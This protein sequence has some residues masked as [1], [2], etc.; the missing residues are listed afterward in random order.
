M[1]GRRLRISATGFFEPNDRLVCARFQ[2]MHSPYPV[3]TI[4]DSGIA[5]AESDGLLEEWDHLLYRP[6]V[7]LAP[8]EL[9]T[10]LRLNASIV[11]YSVI[12]SSARPCARKTWPLA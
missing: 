10:E 5:G 3:I 2:Q 9:A 6:G 8:A 7:K 12:A 1:M 4:V 11:P